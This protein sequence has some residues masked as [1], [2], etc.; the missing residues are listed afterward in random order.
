MI[1]RE[2]AGLL[3]AMKANGFVL[4]DPLTAQAMRALMD[5]PLPGTPVA[6]AA[7]RDFSIEGPGGPLGLRV[8]HPAPGERLPAVVFLHGGGWVIGTLDSHDGLARRLA[9]LARCAVVSVDYRRAPEHPYPAPI[10]DALAAIAALPSL[11]DR[12]EIDPGN[13]AVAGD[14]AGGNIA[15]AAALKL[16]GRAGA[17]RAQVLFYPVTDADFDRPSYRTHDA[18][19][20]LSPQMMRFFWDAY[21]GGAIPDE[22][23]AP[24]AAADLSGMPPATII[25]AGN[26]PLHDEGLAYAIRLIAAGV[27]VDLHDFATAVHGFASFSGLVAI[28]DRAV[29]AAAA[30]LRRALGHGHGAVQG[31]ESLPD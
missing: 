14:S 18:G 13:Y 24:M 22:F 31:G 26:D 5:V 27:T 12:F 29:E 30:G 8:Y 20:M 10:E 1:D 3:E 17:P 28:G 23:A 7:A 2:L 15:I 21:L 16:R 6:I 4:P 19:G 25:L 9:N 11:G